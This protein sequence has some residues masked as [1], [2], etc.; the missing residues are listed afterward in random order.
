M[1]L[2]EMTMNLH[3]TKR[4]I[5]Y[6]EDD[7]LP[8]ADNTLQYKWMLTIFENLEICFLNDPNVFVA[9]NLL[10]YPI[11]GDN[12]TR[13]A[14]D[15]LV[16]FGRPKGRRGSYRQW[17]EG[18]VP[19]QVVFEVTSPG[20]RFGEMTRKFEFYQKF[21]VEEFYQYDPDTNVL[22]GWQRI[23]DSLVTIESMNGWVSP[24][25]K[26]R[27][28]IDEEDFNIYRPD[29]ERFLT[30]SELFEKRAEE[31]ELAETVKQRAEEDRLARL[32]AQARGD[33]ALKKA[34]VLAAKLREMGVD[35]DT[36][37]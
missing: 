24:R 27:F 12:K 13:L 33:A 16:A 7:G 5:V 31:R 19:P 18:G 35:P 29:G 28:E 22:D 26:I 21:G 14:P 20:N 9:G 4:P 11:E 32:Q 15:A 6:P 36:I 2:S 3:P 23:G 10:W 37:N 17:E 30:F 25:L 1:F 8:M 34:E